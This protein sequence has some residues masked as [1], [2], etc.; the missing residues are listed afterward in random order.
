MNIR[1][2][3]TAIAILSTLTLSMPVNAQTKADNLFNSAL[4]KTEL[5]DFTG[6]IADLKQATILYNQKG[7]KVN[8][9]KSQAV[10]FYL[11]E[12]LKDFKIVKR[13]TPIANWY[14]SG[15]CL[16]G[17]PL[18]N[19]MA[20]WITPPVPKSNFGGVILLEKLLRHLDNGSPVS[21]ILDVQVIPKLK[22]GEMLSSQCEIKGKSNENIFAL[23]QYV[24]FENEALYTKVRGTW[25]FNTKTKKIQIL[26][27]KGV[28]CINNC[29]GGSPC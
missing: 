13:D 22:A 28:A 20:Q 17:E 18:C 26:P 14:Q 4:K 24:G 21:A 23:V 3:L 12:E 2:L 7:N 19:Y 6:A 16:P 29:P 1:N 11:E 10:I 15:K 5:E 8:A 27:N 25:F 9:Y